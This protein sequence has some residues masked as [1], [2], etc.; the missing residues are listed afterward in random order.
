MLPPKEKAKEL[1]HKINNTTTIEKFEEQWQSASDYARKDLIRKGLIVVDEILDNFGLV[2]NE[3][4]F[5]TEHRAFD[6]YSK[7]KQELINFR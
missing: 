3:Q 5:Y 2:C 1:L 4:T 7:V 6:Y